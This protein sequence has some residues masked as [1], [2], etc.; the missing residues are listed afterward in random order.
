MTVTSVS[1]LKRINR[2][3][4]G[5][6]RGRAALHAA[7]GRAAV[8]PH[9]VVRGGSLSVRL[10]RSK[11]FGSAGCLSAHGV[12]T[13]RVVPTR[14]ATGRLPVLVR[15]RVGEAGCLAG[16]RNACTRILSAVGAP[17]RHVRLYSSRIRSSDTHLMPVATQGNITSCEPCPVDTYR[18]APQPSPAATPSHPHSHARCRCGRVIARMG[19][20]SVRASIVRTSMCDKV[21]VAFCSTKIGPEP[22]VACPQYSTTNDNEGS[23]FCICASGLVAVVLADTEISHSLM[24]T[25]YLYTT[26]THTHT[27]THTHSL[28]HSPTYGIHT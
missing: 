27:Y 14:A 4:E 25:Y 9:R 18:H 8:G 15:L 17:A 10:Q 7:A 23:T 5:A 11:H 26:H 22:C 24:H 28:T 21:S 2:R 1:D 13:A 6:R 12:L 19:L 3:Y 16:S 20:S